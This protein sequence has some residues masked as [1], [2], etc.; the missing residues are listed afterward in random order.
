MQLWCE[1]DIYQAI[2]TVGMLGMTVIESILLGGDEMDEFGG[3]LPLE[4]PLCNKCYFS[5][6]PDASIKSLNCARNAIAFICICIKP[7]KIYIPYYNCEMVVNTLKRYG[8]TYEQYYLTEKLFPDIEKIGEREWLLYV[9]YFGNIADRDIMAVCKKYSRVI[10]DNTQA[11]Y[12]KPVI[13]ENCYNIY[14]CRKFF[15]VGD[16]AYIVSA[17]DERMDSY[18]QLP[19]DKS[20]NRV[21][22]L[23]RSIEEGTNAA[24]ADSISNEANIGTEIS[25]MSAL[26]EHILNSIDYEKVRERRAEN[27]KV[28]KRELGE[29]NQLPLAIHSENLMVYPFYYRNIYLRR[30]LIKNKIY[31]P[32][33]WKY[34]IGIVQ[35]GSVEFKYSQWLYPLP[36]DQR[37]EEKD[38]LKLCAKVKR[39]LKGEN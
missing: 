4:L 12:A 15:G 34:L 5:K 1:Q 17:E 33:W 25:R 35:E 27:I 16:G 23:L 31:T 37:Y 21:A 8:I 13:K 26:T 22:F 9:N 28:L 6:Y 7:E 36:V 38:M 29:I 32:Q 20:W 18:E 24:Y 39:L 14:S 19:I 30:V 3:F 10:L 11:F 2:K